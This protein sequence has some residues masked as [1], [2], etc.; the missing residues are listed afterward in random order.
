MKKFIK[1]LNFRLFHDVLELAWF[2]GRRVRGGAH[3]RTMRC[4]CAASWEM[5]R[6][7]PQLFLF[8]SQKRHAFL[9]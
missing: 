4:L 2:D 1:R 5:G 9:G 7:E 3:R 8:N 6:G